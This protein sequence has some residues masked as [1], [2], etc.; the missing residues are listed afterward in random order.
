MLLCP[1]GVA[2]PRDPAVSCTILLLP[3]SGSSAVPGRPPRPMVLV[4][5][6]CSEQPASSPQVRAGPAGTRL[7]WAPCPDS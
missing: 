6:P 2:V 1:G 5:G 4:G 3:A 7:L